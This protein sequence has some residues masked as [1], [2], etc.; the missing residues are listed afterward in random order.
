[1][2]HEKWWTMK[3]NELKDK[4]GKEKS[5]KKNFWKK[6]WLNGI[7]WSSC[8]LKSFAYRIAGGQSSQSRKKKHNKT[9]T[10]ED[11]ENKSWTKKKWANTISNKMSGLGLSKNWKRAKWKEERKKKTNRRWRIPKQVIFCFVFAK[12]RAEHFSYQDSNWLSSIGNRSAKPNCRN[13]FIQP[14]WGNDSKRK[15]KKQVIN[16]KLNWKKLMSSSSNRRQHTKWD[17]KKRNDTQPIWREKEKRKR[18]RRS[19]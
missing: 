5:K 16:I 9:H 12:S 2:T 18:K 6:S 1:M 10:V 19:I 15:K 8:V 3:E 7:E 14:M 11:S 13:I 4:T 17:R